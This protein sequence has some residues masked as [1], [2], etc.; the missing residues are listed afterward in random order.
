MVVYNRSRKGWLKVVLF[1]IVFAL[2]MTLTFSGVDGADSGER[3][4][5]AISCNK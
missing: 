3:D 5:T 4:L 2:G 1:I